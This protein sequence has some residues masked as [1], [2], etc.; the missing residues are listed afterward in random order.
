MDSVDEVGAVVFV[1]I[2]L[3]LIGQER[4]NKR[5]RTRFKFELRRL[6]RARDQATSGRKLTRDTN[7]PTKLEENI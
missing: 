4:M 2:W 1:I 6:A 5:N 7:R 3:A